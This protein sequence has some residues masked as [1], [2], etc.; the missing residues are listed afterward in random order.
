MKRLSLK[1]PYD[2][3]LETGQDDRNQTGNEQTRLAVQKTSWDTAIKYNDVITWGKNRVKQY[4][5]IYCI[6]LKRATS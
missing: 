4:V 6:K 3:Y 5:N 1:I 2:A